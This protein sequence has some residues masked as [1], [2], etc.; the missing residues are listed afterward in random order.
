VDDPLIQAAHGDDS[1]KLRKLLRNGIDV[2]PR[3]S[4]STAL[5]I[6]AG[7]PEKAKLLLEAGADPNVEGPEGTPLCFVACWGEV[8]SVRLLLAHGADP[9]L[10]EFAD[11]LATSPLVLSVENGHEEVARV[12][13]AAGADP[14]LA[15]SEGRTPLMAAARRG[16]MSLT[17]LLL[18]HGANPLAE[19][20]DGETALDVAEAWA[21]K[22]LESELRI[23]VEPLAREG[24]EI[25]TRRTPQP[26]GTELL[27]VKIANSIESRLQTGHA[28]IAKLLRA[29]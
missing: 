20:D 15:P 11:E 16:S 18:D 10:I 13:I 26:D 3:S 22:D 14:N 5:Y 12:L 6:A 1:R 27:E 2:D 24:D 9:N 17:R 8:E 19:D 23:G 7:N 21:A 25:V 4:A 28:E 29:L